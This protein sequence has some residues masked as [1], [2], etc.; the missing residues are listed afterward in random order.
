MSE[1]KISKRNGKMFINPILLKENPLNS[2]LYTNTE[3]EQKTRVRIAESYKTRILEGR[4]PNEHPVI[5]WRD[6]NQ[7]GA[8]HFNGI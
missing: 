7:R 1:L 6:G 4:C 3:E 8:I 5:I 2:T